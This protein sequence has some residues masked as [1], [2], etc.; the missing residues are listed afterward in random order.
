MKSDDLKLGGDTIKGFLTG[1]NSFLN[2]MTFGG[3][4]KAGGASTSSAT[5]VAKAVGSNN[6][7]QAVDSAD[8]N[9][10]YVNYTGQISTGTAASS[11]YNS[12]TA[13]AANL[14]VLSNG[15][16]QRSTSAAKYK[17]DVRDLESLD[18]TKLRAVRYKS[19]GAMD[20]PSKDH[21]G[22][23]A[24]EALQAGFTEL[25]TLGDDGEPEGFQYERLTAVLLKG[26]QDLQREFAEYK[27]SHP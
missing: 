4:V 5:I 25:V 21:F 6:P 13:S 24:D 15:I 7:L 22:L 27:A 10:F 8:A 3:K 1:I 18:I 26:L 17:T 16:L 9:L 20:D 14:V 12:T 19:L 23:I 2:D 11:P